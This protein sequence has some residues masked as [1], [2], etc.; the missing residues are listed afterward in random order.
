MEDK[1]FEIL[2][3][4]IPSIITGGVAYYFF[5]SHIK[6][7]NKA[8]KLALL[9]DKKKESL[10][11]KLQAYERML[12]FCERINPSKL[13]L[14]VKPIGTDINSYLQ[15]LNANIE[16]EFEHNMVQQIY[17]SDTTWTAIIAA[18]AA[19]LNKLKLISETSDDANNM[20]E[21]ILIEYSKQVSPSETAITF[22]KS[23]V[24]K[25]I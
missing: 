21:N 4:T 7:E 2:T 5:N 17:I 24:K 20:R 1:I 12:L 6:N 18:K 10:P 16:Q 11:I 19:I 3:Y 9:A 23:E 13:L 8:R 14:R 22:I 25:L 15:L